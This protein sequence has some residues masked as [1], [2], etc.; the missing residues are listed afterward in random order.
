MEV[1]GKR[2]NR[3]KAGVTEGPPE[4]EGGNGRGTPIKQGIDKRRESGL[5][6]ASN[7]LYMWDPQRASRVGFWGFAT[8][9]IAADRR[10]G[11]GYGG[12]WMG[13]FARSVLKGVQT[14]K[15]AM[16]AKQ[17]HDGTPVEEGIA[18]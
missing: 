17:E 3:K 10:R 16:T 13:P 8:R 11:R 15:T 5:R 14:D 12:T 2:K 7:G 18:F 6:G 1:E 9:G 4:K